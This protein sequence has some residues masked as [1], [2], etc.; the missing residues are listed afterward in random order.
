MV[1]A[2]NDSSVRI[3]QV[4]QP[5]KVFLN[6]FASFDMHELDKDSMF[7][8]FPPEEQQLEQEEEPFLGGMTSVETFR[9]TAPSRGACFYDVTSKD[10][11]LRTATES[12]MG[13]LLNM[14]GSSRTAS[15]PPLPATPPN[16]PTSFHD[17]SDN[18]V[19][20][21]RASSIFPW[22]LYTMLED[23]ERDNLTH[24][25]SWVQDGSAF[26]VHKSDLFVEKVMPNYF[27]QT[28][29]ESFR[30]QLN[31]YGFT[32]VSRGKGRGVY[33]HLSFHKYH[34]S[35]CQNITRRPKSVVAQILAR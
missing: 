26:K 5:A 21:D 32:R 2:T 13:D 14:L 11:H 10:H 7:E 17:S 6:S 33:S 35:R 23:V 20:D 28:Q 18:N 12:S 27:D 15:L 29:Y 24:I 4:V 16:P 30:R 34:R 25:V 22:K 3:V 9:S 31:L 1:I 8:L 19:E